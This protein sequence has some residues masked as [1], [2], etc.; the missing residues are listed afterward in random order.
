M[1]ENIA[2]RKFYSSCELPWIG[3]CAVKCVGIPDQ[4]S[5]YMVW[6]SNVLSN[7]Q[8][9]YIYKSYIVDSHKHLLVVPVVESFFLK[10]Q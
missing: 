5:T 1:S 2:C 3:A 7:T 9:G 6:P 10:D 8:Y 4:G